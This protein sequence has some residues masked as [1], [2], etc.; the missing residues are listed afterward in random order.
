MV[1]GLKEQAPFMVFNDHSE[2]HRIL[3]RETPGG[4]PHLDFNDST[5]NPRATMGWIGDK[6]DTSLAFLDATGKRIWRAP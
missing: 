6:A 2:T 3:L 4:S 5:G 1:I